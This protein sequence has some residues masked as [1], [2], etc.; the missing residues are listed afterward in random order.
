MV[1]RREIGAALCVAAL[2]LPTHH[3][4]ASLLPEEQ[5][6]FNSHRQWQ[7]SCFRF[8]EP[9]RELPARL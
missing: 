8:F 7:L 1:A 6:L 4:R 3:R 2:L 5:A 9:G